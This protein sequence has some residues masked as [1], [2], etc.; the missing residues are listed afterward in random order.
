MESVSIQSILE[1][2]GSVYA[3]A[4]ATMIAY[5]EGTSDDLNPRMI[6]IILALADGRY[7]LADHLISEATSLCYRNAINAQWK[8]ICD[9]KIAIKRE[10]GGIPK[11]LRRRIREIRERKRLLGKHKAAYS[12]YSSVFSACAEVYKEILEDFN[13]IEERARAIKSRARFESFYNWGSVIIGGVVGV[14]V[15]GY[16]VEIFTFIRCALSWI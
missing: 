1:K 4:Y 7:S 2:F 5:T 15:A 3:D 10:N 12:E 16:S 11:D 9:S 8:L 13:M 6:V 14:F